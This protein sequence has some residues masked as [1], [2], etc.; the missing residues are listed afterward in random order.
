MKTHHYTSHH[1][2]EVPAEQKTAPHDFGMK[3]EYDQRF[4]LKKAQFT[5]HGKDGDQEFISHHDKLHHD[6]HHHE[7]EH[8]Q[9]TK[10]EDSHHKDRD[11]EHH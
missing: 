6:M 2:L 10:K 4:A 9:E 3:E 1:E 8:T 5:F 11:T 7:G